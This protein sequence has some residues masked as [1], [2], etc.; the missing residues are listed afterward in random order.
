MTREWSGGEGSGGQKEG[1]WRR[2]STGSGRTD[3][4]RPGKGNGSAQGEWEVGRR[5]AGGQGSWEG[6]LLELPGGRP[7]DWLMSR[8]R[9]RPYSFPQN[10][11]QGR[12][13][14]GM[15]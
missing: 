10:A 1:L 11:T 4:L 15:G 2:P 3:G 12:V 9:R 13:N 5:L 14:G 6:D 7:L 8:F